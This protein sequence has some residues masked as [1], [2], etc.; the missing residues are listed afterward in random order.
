MR[1]MAALAAFAAAALVVLVMQSRSSP[2]GQTNVSV[3]G[4]GDTVVGTST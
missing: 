1:I 3:S 4:A 2:E